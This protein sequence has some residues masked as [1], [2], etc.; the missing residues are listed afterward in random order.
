MIHTGFPGR[1]V[2]M[3]PPDLVSQEQE[4]GMRLIL[5][6]GCGW[7]FPGARRWQTR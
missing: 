6:V 7:Y 1:Q 2:H 3:F 5:S 4:A